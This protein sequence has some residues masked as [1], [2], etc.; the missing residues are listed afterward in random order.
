[1]KILHIIDTLA[2]GGAERL[3][4]MLLPELMRQGHQVAVAVRSAPYDLQSELESAGVP[5]IRLPKRHK[6]N[7]IASVRD[8]AHTMSDADILH[9]HLYFP[10][11]TT[12]LTRTMG[13]T[14]AK[15]CLT[16]H[17]LAYA[18]ANRNGLKLRFRKALA[19]RLYPLGIDASLAV[20]QAVANHYHDALSLCGIRVLHN[21]IDLTAIDAV[22]NVQLVHD[23]PLNILLPGRL[24]AEKGHADLMAA[25]R[26]PRLAGRSLTVTFAGHG[27]LHAALQE[28]GSDLPF[29]LT[30]TGN[31][32]HK[33]FLSTMAAADIIV[34]P[35]RFEGFG[36][37][38]LEAMSL[39]KPVIASMAGGLPEVMGDTG[40]L[41]RIGDVEAIVHALAELADD[42]DLRE[43]M[44]RAARA[45]AKDKFD[46]PGIAS[47]LIEVYETL[48]PRQAS[49]T[50]ASAKS[51]TS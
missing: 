26:D 10:A 14:R 4:V 24:V 32:D 9:A 11:V 46:L 20:S 16:F 5:V 30:I 38:A 41:V 22:K 2:R 27:K 48:L 1:M 51:E 44:G 39:S 31:L 25:L 42:Q 50:K 28:I 6:W 12:A 34:I 17:N 37:T 45:R 47:K 43:R 15:T 19:R 13:C 35:S 49:D 8:I 36:L 33:S 23:A 7:L 29:P 21:P 40:H 3:L 18:G